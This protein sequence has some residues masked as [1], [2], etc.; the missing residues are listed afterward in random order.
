ME[1]RKQVLLLAV[2]S[3]ALIAGCSG[4]ATTLAPSPT[5]QPAPTEAPSPTPAA[6]AAAPTMPPVTITPSGPATCVAEPMEFPVNDAIP[7][8]TEGEIIHGPIDA[9]I[10][11]IEYADFQ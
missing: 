9:P 2:L 1:L 5:P 4:G 10:T 7:S 8:V 11:F 6:E 3:L